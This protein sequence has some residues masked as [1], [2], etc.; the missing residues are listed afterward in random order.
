MDPAHFTM[1]WNETIPA[2]T[3][4]TQSGHTTT[5]TVVAGPLPGAEAPLP[6]PPAS[7]AAQAGS[8]V[9]VWIIELAPGAQWQLP[10]ATNKSWSRT[11]LV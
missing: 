6:P 8:D 10:A 11:L 1:Y 7:W 3:T 5:V 4:T 2:C 9:A